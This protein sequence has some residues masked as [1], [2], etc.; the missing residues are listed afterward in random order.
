[1]ALINSIIPTQ[2]YEYIRDAIGSILYTEI[3][4]QEAL[5]GEEYVETYCAERFVPPDETEFTLLNVQFA[6]GDYS[7]KDQTQVD[8]EYFYYISVHTAAKNTNAEDADKRATLKLHKVLGLVRAIL[9]N[10]QYKT[11]AVVPKRVIAGTTISTIRIPKN[12]DSDNAASVITGYVEFRVRTIEDVSLLEPLP[13]ASSVTQ[14]KLYL[15]DKG[16][17]WGADEEIEFLEAEASTTSEPI[18]LI[19]E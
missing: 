2:N 9:M 5:T 17:K 4:N 10:P 12:E 8:S 3:K 18:Y 11:L 14:V 19:A 16:Y 15:T 1:M 6:G 7:N 13:L